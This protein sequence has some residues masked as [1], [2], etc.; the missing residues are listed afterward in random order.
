VSSKLYNWISNACKEDNKAFDD[1]IQVGMDVG[2]CILNLN[3][4]K[5][6]T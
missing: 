5:G 1:F 3:P 2:I 6:A 4:I